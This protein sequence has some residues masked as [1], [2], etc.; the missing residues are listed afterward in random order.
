MRGKGFDMNFVNLQ[1]HASTYKGWGG[2]PGRGSQGMERRVGFHRQ[3]VPGLGRLRTDRR[4]T[5]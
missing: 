3:P 4:G 5:D 2:S 1:G